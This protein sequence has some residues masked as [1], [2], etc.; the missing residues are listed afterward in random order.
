MYDQWQYFLYTLTFSPS[1]RV[2]S[3]ELLASYDMRT[4]PGYDDEMMVLGERGERPG[5]VAL[6]SAGLVETAMADES[7]S[8]HPVRVRTRLRCFV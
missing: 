1:A 3:S 5:Y 8:R 7:S 6:S 2:S 4:R